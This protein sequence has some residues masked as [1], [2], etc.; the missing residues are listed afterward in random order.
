MKSMHIVVK[1]LAQSEVEI[2]VT[3]PW[4]AWKR[5]AAK[6][7]KNIAKD[8]KLPGFRPGKVPQEVIEKKYGKEAILLEA[9]DIAIQE[10]YPEVLRQEK[11]ETIGRPKAEVKEATEGKDLEYVVTTAVMPKATLKPWKD[12][13]KKINKEQAAEKIEVSEEDVTKE[14]DRLAKTRAKFITVNRAAQKDDNVEVDF[15]V[16]R[17]G[18]VIE[19]GTGKKHP[20]VLGSNTFIPGF[21]EQLIGMKTGEEKEFELSF[22]AEYHAKDLAGQ[23]A[24]FKVELR[25]IQE[26]EVP[27]IDD[28]FAQSLGKFMTIDE[29]KANIKE[30]M[31]EE[32]KQQGKEAHQAKIVEELIG[33]TEAA[34]P[35]VMV[36]EEVHKMIH[37]FESQVQSMGMNLDEYLKGLGKTHKDLHKDWVP[38]AEK[39]LKA[40]LALDEVAKDQ[41]IEVAA[42]EVEVEMNKT[43]QYYKTMTDVEKKIDLEKLYSYVKGKMQNE[44]VFEYLL[45][46]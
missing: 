27:V 22:P 16:F 24:T 30:G 3:L 5:H 25:L 9:A 15:Q 39:R 13:V 18:V 17:N 12:A 36:D 41:E 7:A 38:Q 40:A 31:V 1:P 45:K 37:E 19:N 8:V 11:L 2:T 43:L 29:L 14:L 33:L 28:A 6:A 26:R 21:E 10:S 4:E 32:K 42:E 35:A 23:T 34:L 46:L 44:K 20:L